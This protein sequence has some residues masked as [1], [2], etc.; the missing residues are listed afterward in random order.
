[1]SLGWCPNRLVL[2]SG[3]HFQALHNFTILFIVTLLIALLVFLSKM[4]HLNQCTF[5]EINKAAK[6]RLQL[7]LQFQ[8]TLKH[9][10]YLLPTANAVWGKVMFLHLCVI[11]FTGGSAQHPPD[12]DPPGWADPPGVRQ[13]P[14]MQTPWGWA[15]PPGCIHPG[16]GMIPLDAYPPGLG[17]PLS[18]GCRP[19]PQVEQIPPDADPPYSQ[20]AGG[21]HPSGKHT[22][23]YI[24]LNCTQQMN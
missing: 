4:S 22:C 1:M 7:C 18:R 16:V 2:G 12:A 10:L 23:Y 21:T 8:T 17:R 15:D 11:L 20:Q 24:K 14:W 6:P 19:P 9:N 13:T 5:Q 3:D